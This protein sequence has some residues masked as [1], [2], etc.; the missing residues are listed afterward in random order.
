VVDG[1][2]SHRSVV[3]ACLAAFVVLAAGGCGTHRSSPTTTAQQLLTPG[4]RAGAEIKARLQHAGY[5]TSPPPTTVGPHLSFKKPRGEL[6]TFDVQ[7]DF[8]S[9]KSFHVFVAVFATHAA[10]LAYRT[11]NDAQRKAGIARCRKIPECRAQLKGAS[12]EGFYGTEG[13]IG[14]TYYSASPDQQRN[15]I[16]PAQLKQFLALLSASTGG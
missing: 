2:S 10:A 16:P 15:T 13:I 11:V 9:P 4:A 8:T 3:R 6:E 7:V 5:D 1:R 14:P 12:R